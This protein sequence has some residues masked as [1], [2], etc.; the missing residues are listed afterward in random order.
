M[1]LAG[2]STFPKK[3]VFKGAAKINF[4]CNERF[5]FD[6]FLGEVSL[7]VCVALCGVLLKK[8]WGLLDLSFSL[9]SNVKTVF[10]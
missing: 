4:A 6:Y 3:Y 8:K 10:S 1:H 5:A 7:V 9:H 2:F